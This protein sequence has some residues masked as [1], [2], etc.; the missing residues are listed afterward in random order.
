MRL[1]EAITLVFDQRG[2]LRERLE[3]A[4][5]YERDCR[6]VALFLGNPDI[7]M[8]R[9]DDIE[10]Y[11]KGMEDVGYTRNGLQM[12]GCALR[13]LF[14][15]LRRRGYSV[16]D[17]KDI[18]LLR[19]EYKESRVATEEQIQ[20]VL[21][22]FD[23]SPQKHLRLRNKA[24]LLVLRDTGMRCA[25]LRALNLADM[26]MENKRAMIRTKKSRGMKPVRAVFWY[27]ECN[28]A[29][30]EWIGERAKFLQSHG[31]TSEALFLV[32]HRDTGIAR[33]GS[34][35]VGIAMRK[36]S[37]AAGVPTLNPH[38][39]RHRKGHMIAKQGANNSII[40]GVLGHSSLASSY[41]YTMMNDKELEQVARKYGEEQ[42]GG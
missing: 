38:S 30:K 33:I 27:D 12:K 3:T 28:V 14:A 40:S 20:K 32:S 22:V 13:K 25:E 26:D 17:P 36:A 21:A 29:L 24:M 1:S 4:R 16:L 19:R 37:W 35:G 10:R 2:G 9:V 39:L 34:T 8:V 6:Q 42:G 11:F 7:T 15:A 5:G 31:A 23:K 41:V 18:P